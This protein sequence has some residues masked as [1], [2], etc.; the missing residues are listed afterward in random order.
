[1]NWTAK[2]LYAQGQPLHEHSVLPTTIYDVSYEASLIG[3]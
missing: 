1:M 3:L 2:P